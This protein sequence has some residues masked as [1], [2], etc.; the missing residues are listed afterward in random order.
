MG[1]DLTPEERFE[2][3]G[4]FDPDAHADEAKNRWGD[5]DAYKQSARR[6]SKY[7]KDDWKRVMAQQSTVTE[8]L[9]TLF[10]DGAAADSEAAKDAAEAHRQ[11]IAQSFYDCPPQ[12]HA[13]LGEMY[14]ADHRFTEYWDKH[15]EGLAVWVRDAFVANAGRQT[16]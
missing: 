3:F 4:D 5:T 12:M 1:I 14:V 16:A 11:F 15:A 10:Q 9:A 6:T 7:T 13:G 2:V 8:R